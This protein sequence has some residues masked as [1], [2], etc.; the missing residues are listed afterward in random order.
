MLYEGVKEMCASFAVEAR[1]LRWG[2]KER[3]ASTDVE[4]CVLQR[5]EGTLCVICCGSSCFTRC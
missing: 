5:F 1:V 4:A 2:F 3:C